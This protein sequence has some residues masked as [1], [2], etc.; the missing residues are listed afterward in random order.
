[1]TP[2]NSPLTTV[3]IVNWNGRPHLDDCL[4]SLQKQVFADFQVVLV[5]NGSQDD[6]VAFI[7]QFYPEIH[8]LQ[9]PTNQGFCKPNNLAI[10]QTQSKYICLLNNDT[11]LDVECLGALT[12]TMEKE[13]EI[14]ICDA[15]Q[16]L[17]ARRDIIHSVGADYTI[18]GSTA[19]PAYLLKDEG[20]DDN[21]D[22]FIG[23]A[24]CVLYRRTMLDD[25][26][27]L[28]E[29]FFAGCE[30]TDISFR[31]HLTG[32]RVQNVGR[33][34]CYHKISATHKVNSANFV[35]RGQRN[36]HWA[37][38]KNMPSSLLFRYWPHHLL[39]TAITS[40]YFFRVGRGFDWMRAKFDVLRSIPRLMKK[41]KEIQAL[42]RVTDR[43]IDDLLVKRW[44]MRPEKKEKMLTAWGVK[45]KDHDT[46]VL[47]PGS[48]T[49]KS[50]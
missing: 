25:I 11:E 39:Y 5:D 43:E 20:L 12:E 7:R 4:G 44:L 31:A 6:S 32:Y 49:S 29:D 37:Y 27:L 17:F 16:L 38:F 47:S 8:I 18:A 40:L 13:P 24:A 2:S 19:K 15:K 46:A 35:R 23:M 10:R 42:R 36:L 34:R 9:L 50:I 33:A 30:D 22:R 45:G 14:G 48:P 28:D 26:G 41:R 1:M 21:H 3:I